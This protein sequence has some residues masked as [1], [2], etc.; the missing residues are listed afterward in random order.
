MNQ[1]QQAPPAQAP[2]AQP[3]AAAAPPVLPA[4]HP[5]PPA[6]PDHLRQPLLW[7]QDVHT[8]S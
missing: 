1:G 3:A 5:P 4:P 7:D 8:P 2:P 6:G